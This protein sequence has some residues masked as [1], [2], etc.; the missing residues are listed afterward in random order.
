MKTKNK[1]DFNFFSDLFWP[2]TLF[3]AMLPVIM[4]FGVLQAGAQSCDH[5]ALW[6][7]KDYIKKNW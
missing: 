2:A 7:A 6:H 1:K 5:M 3:I 4:I